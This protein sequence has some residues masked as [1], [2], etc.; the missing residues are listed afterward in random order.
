MSRDNQTA[1]RIGCRYPVLPFPN[2][3]TQYLWHALLCWLEIGPHTDLVDSQRNNLSNYSYLWNLDSL[4][5]TVVH[6]DANPPLFQIIEPEH[7]C[8]I[9]VT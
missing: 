6:V 9:I 1:N 7:V 4:C 2:G 8:T 5:N 3:C